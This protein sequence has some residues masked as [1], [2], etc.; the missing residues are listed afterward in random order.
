MG[1]TASAWCHSSDELRWHRKQ[2]GMRA[3]VRPWGSSPLLQGVHLGGDASDHGLVSV[4]SG[5]PKTN[6]SPGSFDHRLMASWSRRLDVWV[7]CAGRAGLLWLL[8]RLADSCLLSLSSHG[9]PSVGLCEQDCALDCGEAC[10][11]SGEGKQGGRG[12]RFVTWLTPTGS[13]V[14]PHWVCRTSAL[15]SCQ[16][17]ALS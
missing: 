2:S 17:W 11:V 15:N 16:F 12:L 5:C 7:E 6:H 9:C 13:R 10:V 4:G 1:F 8:L 14:A 3:S